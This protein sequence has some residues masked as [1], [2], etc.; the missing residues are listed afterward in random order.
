MTVKEKLEKALQILDQK[1][2]RYYEMFEGEPSFE[3]MFDIGQDVAE[4][5]DTLKCLVEEYLE[6]SA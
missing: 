3:N 5:S 1:L 2:T 6:K 4:A